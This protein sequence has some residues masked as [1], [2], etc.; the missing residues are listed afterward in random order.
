MD[1]F[2]GVFILFGLTG[3]SNISIE[4]I[5]GENSANYSQFA[6]ITMARERFQL[7][8]KNI[9]FDNILTLDTRKTEKFHKM[10]EIF[11]K[12]KCNLNLI[13]PSSFLC[14]DET[15]YSF[16]GRCFCRQYIPSKPARY[17]IKYWCLVDIITGYTLSFIYYIKSFF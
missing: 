6:S 7:I 2:I 14:I 3:K 8:V 15:L 16:R 5:W 9:C 13:T 12:F 11:N 10:S 4:E 17:G 1:G